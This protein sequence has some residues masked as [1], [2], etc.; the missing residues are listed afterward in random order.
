MYTFVLLL[1]V[2]RVIVSVRLVVDVEASVK[3]NDTKPLASE[4]AVCDVHVVLR[5]VFEDVTETFG[6]AFP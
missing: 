1:L 5:P 3:L 4:T 2:V 6:R